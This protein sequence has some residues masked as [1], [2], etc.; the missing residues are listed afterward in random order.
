SVEGGEGVLSYLYD[1]RAGGRIES[2]KL[3]FILAPRGERLELALDLR[4]PEGAGRM[5]V[6]SSE[7]SF[8]SVREIF[9]YFEQLSKEHQLDGSGSPQLTVR[10]GKKGDLSVEGKVSFEGV[11]FSYGDEA[12]R[13]GTGAV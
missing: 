2:E 4:V 9:P 13:N 1:P 8:R 5:D 7:L 6:R 3:S 12:F 11:H 10:F